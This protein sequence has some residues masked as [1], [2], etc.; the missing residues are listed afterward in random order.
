MK[1]SPLL[2]IKDAIALAIDQQHIAITVKACYPQHR[3][4]YSAHYTCN[5]AFGLASQLHREPLEVA[6]EL[7]DR[8]Q[9]RSKFTV[10]V[11]GKGWLNFCLTDAFWA[12]CL[13]SLTELPLPNH[14]SSRLNFPGYTYVQYAYA[15][16]HS[17]LR[18]AANQKL[19]GEWNL[20]DAEGKLLLQEESELRLALQCLAIGDQ[21]S[22]LPERF[23]PPACG[24]PLKKG[25]LIN[26][27][28]PPFVKVGW[29]GSSNAAEIKLCRNLATSF[30]EFSDRCRIFSVAADLALVRIGLV[31]ITQKLIGILASSYIDL[32]E[33]L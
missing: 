18:L 4:N 7:S 23:D 8:I 12:E 13:Y 6:Q 29:E 19:V 32:P 15:Q 28:S 5:V 3:I 16:C 1:L 10:S 26:S 27:S 24:I 31:N 11:A 33:I 21:I 2:V 22:R 30:L 17:L 20:L 9:D 25:D 14:T